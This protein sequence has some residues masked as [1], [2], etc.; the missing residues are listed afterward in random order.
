M[1][2]STKCSWSVWV[3]LP[4]LPSPALSRGADEGPAVANVSVILTLLAAFACDEQVSFFPQS[5][6]APPLRFPFH[7]RIALHTVN[8][9]TDLL[10]P[11]RP[12]YIKKKKKKSGLSTQIARRPRSSA[13][14]CQMAVHPYPPAW[15][16][17]KGEFSS[18]AVR[19]SF[20]PLVWS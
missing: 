14:L 17:R 10:V 3:P 11:V 12:S 13:S 18:K 8:R 5:F 15:E 20:K 19:A 4:K 9:A 2:G 6:S 1:P 16:S 7:L